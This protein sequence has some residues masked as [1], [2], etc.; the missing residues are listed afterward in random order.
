MKLIGG[1]GAGAKSRSLSVAVTGP[2]NSLVIGTLG[3]AIASP[4]RL[5]GDGIVLALCLGA[6][7]AFAINFGAREE[8]DTLE[9]RLLVATVAFV[10]LTIL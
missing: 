5:S 2:I 10:A 3:D 6:G 4:S 8:V 7:F 9:V 1:R